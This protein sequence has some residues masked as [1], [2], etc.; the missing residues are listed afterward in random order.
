MVMVKHEE[1]D[2]KPPKTNKGPSF[3]LASPIDNACTCLYTLQIQQ[4]SLMILVEKKNDG[5]LC[6]LCT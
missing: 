1:A 6:L 4:L 5:T 2:L 3:L